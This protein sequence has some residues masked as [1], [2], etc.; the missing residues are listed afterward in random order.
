MRNIELRVGLDDAYGRAAARGVIRY[1]KAKKDWKLYG[2]GRPFPDPRELGAD[3]VIAR[4]ESAADARAL[5][6]LGIP[7]VDIAGAFPG[8]AFPHARFYEANNDDFLTGRRAGEY[9]RSLGFRTFAFCG[10][11]A[12][13]W[14][15]VRRAGFAEA[16]GLDQRDLPV[17]ERSLEWWKDLDGEREVLA[18]WLASLPS[19]AA[20]FAC[21]DVAGLK[22]SRTCAAAGIEVPADVA[23]LGADDED[24]LCELADPS[25]S[26]VRLDCEGIGYAAAKLLDESLSSAEGVEY[27]PRLVPPREI[28][29]RE[30]TRTVAGDDPLVSRALSWIRSNAARGVNVAD[31]VAALPAS[32]RSLE[33]RFRAALGVT[34]HDAIVDARLDRAKRLLTTTDLTLDAVA[35]SSGFGA[36]QRFHIAFKEREG[37]TPGAWRKT[38]R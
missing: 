12:V 23:V 4:V 26:S 17:F 32:R 33:Q 20:L 11:A 38:R 13:A 35:E 7:V 18:A 1:A 21:N 24:L 29:E 3:G 22:A 6:A 16:S 5:S 30:S 31:A 10:V 25:L 9:L 19:P 2:T 8:A 14:S 36:L 27:R 28:V 34:L 37:L 15:R